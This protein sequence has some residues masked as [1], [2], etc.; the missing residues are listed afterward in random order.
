MTDFKESGFMY[1][2]G[3]MVIAVVMGQSIFFLVKAYK[4]GIELGMSKSSLKE[5]MVS[6]ALF[7]VAPALAIV[8]TILALSGSL[9]LVLP[10]IRLS[11]I[12]NISQETAAASAALDTVGGSISQEVTDPNQ[13][14]L[15]TWVMTLGSILPLIILPLFLKKMQKGINKAVKKSTKDNSKLVDSLAAAAFIGLISAF[16][17]RAI[18]GKGAAGNNPYYGKTFG[19]GAG[20]MSVTTLVVAVAVML[21]LSKIAEKHHIK[22]LETFAMPISMFAAMGVA[23]LMAQVLPANIAYLEWRG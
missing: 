14:T 19:D 20:I 12:G 4:R 1:A 23:I 7:T 5:T 13:F 22:W 18:D 8:A 15:I 10:W 21:I 3:V 11:V 2:V 17:A 9:G 16:I 6:S